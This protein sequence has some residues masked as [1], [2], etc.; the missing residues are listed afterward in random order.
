MSTAAAPGGSEGAQPKK[1]FQNCW[2]CR[3]LCGSGV[4]ASGVYVYQQA[5]KTLR[6]GRPT[7]MGTVA[8]ITFAASLAALG[9]VI[10]FDPVGDVKK[11]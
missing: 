3:I 2:S 1:R 10:I 4:L 7:S 5:R 8:Q 11:T 9:A 6:L